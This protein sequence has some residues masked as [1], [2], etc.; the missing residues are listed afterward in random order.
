MNSVAVSTSKNRKSLSLERKE[1]VWGYVF[2]SPWIVGFLVF[3][4]GPLLFSLY[5]SF[6]NYDITSRME[7]VGLQNYD[8]MFNHDAL[9]WK[10][11][12]N[13]LFYVALNVP[14]TTIGSLLLA[15]ALNQKI[16]GMR[17]FRT[18]FYLPSVLSGVAVFILWMMLLNPTSGLVNVALSWF[19][20]EGP[21]W[22]V[23]PAWT[24]PAVILMKL[25]AVGGGMLL[26]L[27][28]LQGVPEQLYEAAEI[29]GAGALR[30]FWHITVPMIT[31]VL[32][33]ELI[34]HF[35]SGFQIFQ[36]GYVMAQD[37]NSPGSPMNSLLFYNLH[38]F[39]KAFRV[40]EM[41]YA[42]AMAWFLFA[43]VMVLTAINMAMSKFWVHYE[44][45]DH[46]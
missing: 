16:P 46:R 44:G 36:E 2:V 8:T 17:Y 15:V 45:G 24:K 29:D 1:S 34:T 9:F 7:W 19:G 31:P 3:T 41:G 11:L 4:L 28:S 30:K 32:F 20:I 37:Q 25:W 38:M 18:I 13:T 42:S 40:Y 22:M 33:F 35:I 12:Q 14:L 5:A 26:Y 23:D 39:L 6:T 21:A 27:A 10:S 43:I